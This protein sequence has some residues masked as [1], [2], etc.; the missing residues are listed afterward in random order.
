MSFFDAL[1]GILYG[2]WFVLRVLLG[3]P[4]G[5]YQGSGAIGAIIFGF[6]GWAVVLLAGI[7]CA[8][9]YWLA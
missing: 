7:I 5:G 4:P 2:M 6:A 8:L 3:F 1:W 9:L